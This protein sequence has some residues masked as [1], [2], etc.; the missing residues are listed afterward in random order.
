MISFSSVS[1]VPCSLPSL[2]IALISSSV[3]ALS[4]DTLTLKILKI[5]LEILLSNQT[6]GCTMVESIFIGPATA[7]A[8]F[9]ALNMPSL[10]GTSSPNMM[11]KNVTSITIRTVEMVEA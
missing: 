10:L 11:D 2:I 1:M 4:D 5:I 3:T 7:R 9:S 6:M 8:I